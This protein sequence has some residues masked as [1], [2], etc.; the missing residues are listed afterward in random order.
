MSNVAAS[1]ALVESPEG[2]GVV[3]IVVTGD[4]VTGSLGND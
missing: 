4:G 3:D 2:A 1:P